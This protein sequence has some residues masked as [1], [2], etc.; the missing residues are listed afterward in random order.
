M[1][2]VVSVVIVFIILLTGCTSIGTT[3]KKD[4][5]TTNSKTIVATSTP[6][7]IA[8]IFPDLFSAAAKKVG[9]DDYNRCISFMDGTKFKYSTKKPTDKDMGEI[10]IQ[11]DN[12]FSLSM[13][14]MKDNNGHDILTILSYSDNS[15]EGS[16][17]DVYYNGK[18]E[19][20]TYDINANPRN[21]KV[22]SVRDI[23]S[24]IENEVPK[25]KEK[26]E[27]STKKNTV[28]NVT[29]KASY[30]KESGKTYI[31][32]KTNLPDDTSLSITLKGPNNYQAQSKI[33]IKNGSGK[34]SGFSDRGSQLKSGKYTVEVT[35]PIPA[36]Q[37]KNVIAVIGS[38]GEYLKGPYVTE[39]VFGGDKV[40][41]GT[42][43]LQIN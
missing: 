35:M 18:I 32:I 15:Y 8:A 34:S 11:D 23:I 5:K 12:G 7:E 3:N 21:V 2:K 19:Y 13:L 9:K 26:Y 42:F 38:N 36:V 16:V 14:F 43:K 1:K 4:I 31:I 29:L 27:S 20:N 41:E 30:K 25:R 28:I 24:F 39:S 37:P 40:V 6:V 17:S 10:T 33:T 22:S